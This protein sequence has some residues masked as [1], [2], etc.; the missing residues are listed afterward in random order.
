MAL[1]GIYFL[2]VFYGWYQWSRGGDAHSE[3]PITSLSKKQ[4]AEFAI[5][6][7]IGIIAVYLILQTT[8]SKIPLLDAT[9][10]VLS[11]IAQW[12]ICKKIIQCWFLWFIVDA[13]YIG[14]YQY[15]G[16]PF[17]SITLAIYLIMAIV[18]YW[19]W[20]KHSSYS[21]TFA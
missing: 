19:R 9:T 11:L 8:D 2:S 17:H 14:L 15:K 6:A 3:L 18:G 5:I 4:Y 20:K 1:E 16:M 21:V 13:M 12:M 10:T 7:I